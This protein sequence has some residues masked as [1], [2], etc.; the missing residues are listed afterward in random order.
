MN[1]LSLALG[2]E[3]IPE[4]LP[5][6]TTIYGGEHQDKTRPYAKRDSTRMDVR[7]ARYIKAHGKSTRAEVTG[8]LRH[9]RSKVTF[10]I[11][12][13]YRAGILV[14]SVAFP[15]TMKEVVVFDIAMPL[16]EVKDDSM[17]AVFEALND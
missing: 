14:P 7:V 4:M 12:Q 13:L 8:G 6:G 16:P 11:A 9:D 3:P 17:R 2:L 10:A 5:V 15:C 1:L